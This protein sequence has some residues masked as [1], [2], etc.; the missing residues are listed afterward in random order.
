MPKHKRSHKK[1][2]AHKTRRR[3][4]QEI[5]LQPVIIITL[6]LVLLVVGAQIVR[7]QNMFALTNVLGEKSEEQKQAEESQKEAAKQQEESRKES[8]KQAKE[9]EKESEKSSSASEKSNSSGSSNKTK[10]KTETVSATGTKIKTETEG[11]KQ[12]MEIETAD[13]QKIKTKIE[14][15]GTTKIEVESGELKLKYRVENGKLVLKAED[16]HGDEV[17]LEDDELS[18]LEDSVHDSLSDDDISLTPNDDDTITVKKKGVGA[19]SR[20]PISINVATNELIIT[21]PAGT[22]VVTMLP[23]QAIANMLRNDKVTVISPSPAATTSPS[24]PPDAS[25]PAQLDSLSGVVEL[26]LKDDEVVYKIK[27]KKSHRVLGIV[28]VETEATVFVSAESGNTV[29]T[30]ESLLAQLFDL[31]SP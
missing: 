21:T 4:A 9:A 20:F 3:F 1:H 24:L 19:I 15:D 5:Q 30:D 27:G 28:P 13:G 17:E 22:K 8:E 23:D 14:D 2:S 18:E 25:S 29:D 11:S 7:A 16:E 12:E 31:L 10:S 26:E 6:V